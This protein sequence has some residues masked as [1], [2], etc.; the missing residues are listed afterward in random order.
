MKNEF[1]KKLIAALTAAVLSVC[2]FAGCDNNDNDDDSNIDNETSVSSGET[3]EDESSEE[4]SSEDTSSEDISSE[5]TSSVSEEETVIE[6]KEPAE[7]S[8]DIMDFEFSFDG[9]KVGMD[10][11][12]DYLA[13]NGWT[14]DL[15]DYGYEDGYALEPGQYLLGGGFELKNDTYTSSYLSVGLAYKNTTDQTLDVTE[16]EFQSFSVE[17]ADIFNYEDGKDLP[18]MHLPKGLTWGAT[19][20]EIV[21]AYG[22]PAEQTVSENSVVGNSDVIKYTDDNNNT[23]SFVVNENHGLERVSLSNRF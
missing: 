15:A 10:V 22:E 7:I 5:D 1:N 3:T 13:D 19:T 9:F 16:C 14:F 2:T 18:E 8:D 12:R 11:N 17:V 23:F 20:D 4:D 6:P 21:E